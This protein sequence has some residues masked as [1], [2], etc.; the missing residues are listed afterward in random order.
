MK[1]SD[2]RML[3]NQDLVEELRASIERDGRITF[4]CFMRIALYHPRHG[5]Y[6]NSIAR[7]GRAG[8]FITSPEAHP[9]FGYAV[10]RQIAQMSDLLGNPEPFTIREYGAGSGALA[11][12]VLEGIEAESPALLQ[13]V[14]YEPVELNQLRLEELR[15]T[16]ETQGFAEQLVEANDRPVIG[17]VLAN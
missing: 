1:Q 13:S 14:R 3:S 12:A 16:L 11:L 8:D 7:P 9:I 17:C 10:A 15:Q 5:Y 6:V 4:E 2:A